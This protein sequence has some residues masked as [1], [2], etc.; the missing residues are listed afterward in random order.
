MRIVH[1]ASRQHARAGTVPTAAR[2]LAAAQARANGGLVQ[3]VGATI[4]PRATRGEF[5]EHGFALQRPRCLGRSRALRQ[6]LLNHPFEVVH[7]HCL[8]ERALHYARLAAERHGAPLVISPAGAFGLGAR[9]RLRARCA[10]QRFFVHAQALEHAAGWHATSTEEAAAIQSA[11]FRQ[12]ICVAPPGVRTPA[13]AELA[14]ARAWWRQQHPALAT[15]SVALCCV[16]AACAAGAHTALA[17]W[18]GLA[19]RDW[20]LLLVVD[21]P[22]LAA[23][24]AAVAADRGVSERV[25]IAPAGERPP[26]AVANVF[27]LPEARG[28][29]LCPVAEALAAG[30][31]VLTTDD[32]P[33]QRLAV[34]Q[35]GW[36]VPRRELGP[37]LAHMLATPAE[38]LAA[39]GRN[40]RAL[41]EREF[42]WTR[43]AELLLS[44]YRNLRG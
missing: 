11:G 38:T 40:A 35:A 23:R 42:T 39:L 10:F 24:L 43:S 17:V 41:A 8:G 32:L 21:S 4:K 28:C 3:L 36:C 44:F 22:A 9:E 15:R 14:E 13:A 34:D 29:P 5:E 19:A 27:L 2:A 16:S 7:A 31:P 25:L 12:P 30:L 20:L 1:V 37:A 18:S 33:W 6:H 26:H